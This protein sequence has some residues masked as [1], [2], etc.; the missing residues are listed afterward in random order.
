MH[1][2]KNMH[3]KNLILAAIYCLSI[4]SL[5]GMKDEKSRFYSM[6]FV[7][8][9]N[10]C[11]S[12]NCREF[13]SEDEAFFK[14]D[15]MLGVVQE[16]KDGFKFIIDE[17]SKDSDYLKE[18][19]WQI[20]AAIPRIAASVSLSALGQAIKEKKTAIDILALCKE[21]KEILEKPILNMLGTLFFPFGVARMYDQAE[22]TLERHTILMDVK[23]KL[24]AAA[25][26]AAILS[27]GV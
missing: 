20:N 1:Q 12:R 7:D 5:Y 21:D 13:T 17:E 25:K 6:T 4:S 22:K 27:L 11:L 26:E 19:Y 3:K 24:A 18:N 16:A 15:S 8:S 2:G 9:N 10:N 14:T 23:K